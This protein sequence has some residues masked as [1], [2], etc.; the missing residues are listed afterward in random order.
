MD[1]L[2]PIRRAAMRFLAMAIV[3][4][5]LGTPLST[6]PNYA[7]DT[8]PYHADVFADRSILVPNSPYPLVALAHDSKGQIYAL[9]FDQVVKLGQKGDLL[10]RIALHKG[11]GPGEVQNYPAVMTIGLDDYLYIYD[12]AKIVVYTADLT[13]VRNI[14][15]MMTGREIYV[16][17]AGNLYCRKSDF[18][19][20]QPEEFWA[21]YDSQGKLAGEY[22]RTPD[23]AMSMAGGMAIRA[24]HP[25]V[26]SNI[27]CL[28]SRGV[29]YFLP[30]TGSQVSRLDPQGA[31]IPAFKVDTK[32]IPISKD[33]KMEVERIY[34]G[35]TNSNAPMN[36][37]LHYADH[38]PY[39]RK[40]LIDEPG[41][42]YLVRTES[43]LAKGKEATIDIYQAG[44]ERRELRLGGDPLIVH[45]GYL[46]YLVNKDD[47]A[48]ELT[49]AIMRARV[50]D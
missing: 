4:A 40:I 21:K 46:Y 35:G 19:A 34:V 2:K 14:P 33:E 32:D 8:T 28:D 17:K 48:G 10:K 44:H 45:E 30:N 37:E 12:G 47:G 24:P 20:S 27:F 38:R 22:I 26:P 3:A 15:I 25:Y 41:R 5:L 11:Q 42:F 1:S 39:Y 9:A 31:A 16:D 13:F 29:I 7:Q 43:V 23:L 49:G 50:L 36:V 6:S 18:G